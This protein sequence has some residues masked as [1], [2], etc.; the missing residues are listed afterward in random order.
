MGMQA[1]NYSIGNVEY[2]IYY[3]NTYIQAG[4][5]S[6]N[7]SVTAPTLSLIV[8]HPDYNSSYARSYP[9]QEYNP[10]YFKSGAFPFKMT[11]AINVIRHKLTTTNRSSFIAS[12]C[13]C[14]ADNSFANR[15]NCYL[16]TYDHVATPTSGGS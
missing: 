1:S 7:V 11:S 14:N 10:Q 6:V 8:S 4:Y 5:A 15:P 9:H 12:T 13:D 16:L 3:K 2:I